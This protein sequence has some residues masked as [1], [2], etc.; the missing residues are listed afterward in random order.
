MKTQKRLEDILSYKVISKITIITLLVSLL[1]L[2]YCSFFDYATGDDLWEGAV[3]YQIIQSGGSIVELFK[4]VFAWIK[5]DYLGWQ[6][7]WSST[8]L[9]CFSPN[10]F[11]EKVYCITPW[12]GLGSICVGHWY[13]FK[14]FNEKYLGIKKE[15]LLILYAIITM[16]TIQYMPYIRGAFTGILL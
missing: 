10:V 8:F 3:A 9:W 15:F 16:L 6:G 12:I 1:P 14:H 5:I 7:N 4:E 11:G 13:C 2:M